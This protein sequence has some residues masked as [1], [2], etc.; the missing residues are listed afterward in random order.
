M[1][2]SFNL[3][4]SFSKWYVSDGVLFARQQKKA[5]HELE[6]EPARA[7]WKKKKTAHVRPDSVQ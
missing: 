5:E 1:S 7:R 2:Q 3:S 4:V 6:R